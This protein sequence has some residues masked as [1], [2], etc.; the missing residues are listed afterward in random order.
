MSIRGLRVYSSRDILKKKA[1]IILCLPYIRTHFPCPQGKVLSFLSEIPI[2]SKAALNICLWHFVA[3][4]SLW[5]IRVFI[6]HHPG[7][8]KIKKILFWFGQ[9]DH[10]NPGKYFWWDLI[11][12]VEVIYKDGEYLVQFQLKINYIL[13]N[14]A[15]EMVLLEMS[16]A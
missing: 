5:L 10:K 3:L 13:L 7:N 14:V 4:L 8:L 12:V 1:F 11:I 16:C 15:T 9:K 2:E 6:S